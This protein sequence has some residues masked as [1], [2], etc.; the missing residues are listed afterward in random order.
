MLESVDGESLLTQPTHVT[1][2]QDRND[3]FASVHD[4]I[5]VA[6][7]SRH[8]VRANRCLQAKA[9]NKDARMRP[10]EQLRTENGKR[11]SE[12]LGGQQVTLL[13]SLNDRPRDTKAGNRQQSPCC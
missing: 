1:K 10:S 7:T 2:R 5:D 8:Q 13:N 11:V 9:V 12:Q 6:A 3:V 4:T